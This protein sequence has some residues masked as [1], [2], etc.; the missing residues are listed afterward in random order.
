MKCSMHYPL[1]QTLVTAAWFLIC[2]QL[3]TNPE[4]I[5]TFEFNVPLVFRILRGCRDGCTFEC[6]PRNNTMSLSQT[7]TVF[8]SK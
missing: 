3:T 6:F 5:I 7:I 1:V 4:I 2:S 8:Q